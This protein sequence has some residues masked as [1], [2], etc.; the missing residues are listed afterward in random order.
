V[1]DPVANLFLILFGPLAPDRALGNHGLDEPAKQP[2][3]V[4]L[5][6]G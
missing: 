6:L 3:Q 2:H 1:A 5:V 4:T